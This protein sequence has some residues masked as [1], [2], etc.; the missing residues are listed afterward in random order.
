MFLS[1]S[2][3]WPW[4]SSRS[5]RA[6]RV[7]RD[8]WIPTSDQRAL[9]HQMS[10]LKEGCHREHQLAYWSAVWTHTISLHCLVS[11]AGNRE[12]V[13]VN[14]EKEVEVGLFMSL[15]CSSWLPPPA[16]ASSAPAPFFSSFLR[17]HRA[18]Q[19]SGARCSWSPDEQMNRNEDPRYH[20]GIIQPWVC[21]PGV[22]FTILIT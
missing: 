3:A 14:V 20:S 22:P 11:Q 16:A 2:K 5:L 8:V 9:S 12:R 21:I 19:F 1:L 17:W 15:C 13:E 10:G 18:H 4:W 6:S 7:L